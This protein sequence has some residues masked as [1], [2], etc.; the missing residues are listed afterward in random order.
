[1]N[2]D[3]GAHL[4]RLVTLV[5]LLTKALSTQR[6]DFASKATLL[7]R[8]GPFCTRQRCVGVPESKHLKRGS[9]GK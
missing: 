1:M 8:F 9:R 5:E 6:K 2:L 4:T 7:M 3:R